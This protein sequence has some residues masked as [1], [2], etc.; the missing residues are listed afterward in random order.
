[1]ASRRDFL[2]SIL[3]VSLTPTLSWADAGSPSYLAAAKTQNGSFALFGLDEA[4]NIRF[5]IPLPT[6]GHAAAAHPTRPEAVAFARRP[7][8]YA[9]VIDCSTGNQIAQ[10]TAPEGRHFY[11][12]G[13]FSSDGETLFTTE[14]AYETG[15]GMIGIWD[16]SAGYRR[17]GEITSGGIGPHEIRRLP[18]TETLVVANGGIKTDPAMARMKLNL[19]TMR[20][21]LSYI[22]PDG[23][24][25]EQ[26]ML[27]AEL[28]QN[29]IR[30]IAIST[31]GL[32]GM[33][34]QWQGPKTETPPLLALHRLGENPTILAAELSEHRRLKGY[35]GSIAIS[36]NAIAITSPLGG[37]A[38][39]FDLRNNQISRVIEQPDICGLAPHKGGFFATNGQGG[40]SVISAAG[41]AN[42]AEM[43]DLA[44]DNHAVAIG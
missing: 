22:S 20:P 43:P 3:A 32:V 26:V 23:A 17:I 36:G 35:A 4:A 25:I 18:N 19:D 42:L 41:Q 10:L 40:M 6:R 24:V 27:G 13:C 39:V 28:A 5:S 30:H 7:G 11:G 37:R 14:N 8:T 34:M 9:I 33:A 16:R 44:W 38:H 2:K 15:D 29:S 1:M 31:D 12:H 21:N